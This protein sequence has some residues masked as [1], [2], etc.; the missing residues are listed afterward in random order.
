[1]TSVG[2]DDG[3]HKNDREDR[4]S[5]NTRQRSSCQVSTTN[6][7]DDDDIIPYEVF[8][9]TTEINEIQNNIVDEFLFKL[10]NQVMMIG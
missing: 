8:N 3:P 4:E 2:D 9:A 5:I 1:M 7:P 6:T 10:F